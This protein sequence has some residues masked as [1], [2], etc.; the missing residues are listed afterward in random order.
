[1]NQTTKWKHRRRM[2]YMALMSSIMSLTIAF[3]FAFIHPSQV[4][5]VLAGVSPIIIGFL[6]VVGNYTAQARI[7]EKP[8]NTYTEKPIYPDP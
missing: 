1:M 3:T 7:D 8:R 6:A 2:S 5:G 4:A